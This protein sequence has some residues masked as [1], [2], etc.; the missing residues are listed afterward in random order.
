M[1]CVRPAHPAFASV[2]SVPSCKNLNRRVGREGRGG[3]LGTAGAPSVH[4]LGSSVTS[5]S[6]CKKIRQEGREGWEERSVRDGVG[7]VGPCFKVFPVLLF[8]HVYSGGGAL[9]VN[10]ALVYFRA[11]EHL[12]F[13]VFFEHVGFS[14][15]VAS[16]FLALS[17]G[18]GRV[19]ATLALWGNR[20]DGFHHSALCLF[21]SRA[22]VFGINGAAYFSHPVMGGIRLMLSSRGYSGADASM[23]EMR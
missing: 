21:P 22:L 17:P 5:V 7:A 1:E 13:R 4:V 11:M 23:D 18:R 8:C 19:F 16:V 14:L 6:S 3:L 20:R 10:P 12:D 15:A 2:T 9:V